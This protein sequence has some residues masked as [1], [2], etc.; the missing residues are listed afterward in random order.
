MTAGVFG[1]ITAPLQRQQV[2]RTVGRQ[3]LRKDSFRLHFFLYCSSKHKC[4]MQQLYVSILTTNE[5]QM[6]MPMEMMRY[7]PVKLGLYSVR[8]TT[9]TELRKRIYA[10]TRVMSFILHAYI[11]ASARIR[12]HSRNSSLRT[13]SGRWIYLICRVKA[14]VY[15]EVAGF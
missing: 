3:H 8:R 14:C 15:A 13:I 6:M 11:S 4:S 1:C 10:D 2:A 5:Y 12:R 9:Q 7:C